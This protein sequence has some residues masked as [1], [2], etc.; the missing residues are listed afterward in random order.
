MS[1]APPG[2][3][4]R[5]AT[6]ADIPELVRLNADVQQHHID[7][8]PEIYREPDPEAVAAWMQKVMSTH[9]ILIAERGGRA[10]G[11]LIFNEVRRE[12]NAFTR[13]RSFLLVDQLGVSERR[14]GVG[15]ALMEHVQGVARERGL[16]DVELEVRAANPS[17]LAFYEALSYQPIKLRLRRSDVGEGS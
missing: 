2:L 17:A 16:S 10:V 5:V 12:A 7:A 6:V 11:Y 4:I 9:E 3:V 15:R 14:Q 1:T 8:E 13:A